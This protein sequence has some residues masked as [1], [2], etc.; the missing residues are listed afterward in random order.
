MAEMNERHKVIIEKFQELL[1]SGK[2]Y[3]VKYMYD[4]AGAIVYVKGGSVPQIINK[5]YHQIVSPEMIG[6]IRALNLCGAT[7]KEEVILFSKKFEVCIR[8]SI[9]LIRY[10]RRRNE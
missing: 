9:L 6:Y 4:E 2:D 1:R 10:I 5:H 8:E 3:S 7:R